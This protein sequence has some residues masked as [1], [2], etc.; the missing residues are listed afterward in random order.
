VDLQGRC[1]EATSSKVVGRAEP[2]PK[3]LSPQ[4]LYD[5]EY[6]MV[7]EFAERAP[8]SFDAVKSRLF[9]K[10]RAN[11]E[12][13]GA[14]TGWK[15]QELRE[16]ESL[17][18]LI[19]TDAELAAE[20]EADVIARLRP[21]ALW[22]QWL[23]WEGRCSR[24]MFVAAMALIAFWVWVAWRTT[25]PTILIMLIPAL[26]LWVS[27]IIRRLHDMGLSGGLIVP[28]WLWVFFCASIYEVLPSAGQ[29][30][31][32]WLGWISTVCVFG[33]LALRP[34]TPRPNRY[35]YGRRQRSVSTGLIES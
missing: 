13:W 20:Q 3:S 8:M 24:R 23:S 18:D 17:R 29:A 32:F 21:M 31:V 1:W 7:H 11:P 14:A 9:Q 4:V 33:A 6:R 27:A 30:A 19:R 2:W 22:L 10:V 28:W 5:P 35:G 25:M 15:Y 34:G 16:A 26:S 12:F